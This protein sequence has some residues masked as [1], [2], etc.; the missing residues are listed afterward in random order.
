MFTKVSS[1]LL[2]AN[3][4]RPWLR[5]LRSAHFFSVSVGTRVWHEKVVVLVEFVAAVVIVAVSVIVAVVVVVVFVVVVSIV[6]VVVV[7]VVMVSVVSVVV[8]VV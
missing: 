7:V 3:N 1:K 4:P 6:L 8:V 2:S 5:T